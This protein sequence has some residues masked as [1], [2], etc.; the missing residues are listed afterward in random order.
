[1][2][3][4]VCTIRWKGKRL[5]L[6][7]VFRAMQF[8]YAIQLNEPNIPSAREGAGLARRL[9]VT[10]AMTPRFL[11]LSD[12]LEPSESLEARRFEVDRK[13]TLGEFVVTKASVDAAANT[14]A[15]PRSFM[16]ALNRG[17]R[18]DSEICLPWRTTK[19]QNVRASKRCQF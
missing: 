5:G 9:K 11:R 1:L 15:R 10:A 16:I 2:V 6:K 4:P 12:R 3:C 14:R 7:R 17:T 13:A 8:D 19:V 18:R